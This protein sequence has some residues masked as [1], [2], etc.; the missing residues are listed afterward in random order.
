MSSATAKALERLKEEFPYKSRSWYQRCL[1]RVRRG[2]V[3]R[4]TRGYVVLGDPKLGDA[5]TMYFVD[6]DEGEGRWRCSCYD[7][8]RF[9][10]QRRRAEVCTHVGAVVLYRILEGLRHDQ[11]RLRVE[12]GPPKGAEGGP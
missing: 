12:E 9:W 4:L 10:S 5:H 7:P 2:S 3:R 8:I 6:Y 1:R 11:A